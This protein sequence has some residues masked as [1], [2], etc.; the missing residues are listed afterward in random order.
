M[1]TKPSSLEI[2]IKELQKENAHLKEL[3]HE[4][5]EAMTKDY[6][7][8]SGLIYDMSQIVRSPGMYEIN[9]QK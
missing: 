7:Y 8:L 2:H 4:T 9:L 5:R 3:L 6:S 1:K